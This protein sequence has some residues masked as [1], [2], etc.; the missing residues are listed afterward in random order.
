MTE[1]NVF[2]DVNTKTKLVIHLALVSFQ[3]LFSIN[4]RIVP[5][6]EDPKNLRPVFVMNQIEE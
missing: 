1:T 4:A 3:N 6:T 5:F 2:V